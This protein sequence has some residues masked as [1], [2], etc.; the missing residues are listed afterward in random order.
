LARRIRKNLWFANILCDQHQWNELRSDVVA[1]CSDVVALCLT[2]FRSALALLT[3]QKGG[4]L[5]IQNAPSV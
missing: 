2:L 4:S 5:V 3:H 1:W